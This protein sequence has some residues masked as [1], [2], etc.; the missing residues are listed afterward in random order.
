MFRPA[1]QR[2]EALLLAIDGVHLRSE[3]KKQPGRFN[4]PASC[5]QRGCIAIFATSICQCRRPAQQGPQLGYVSE[6]GSFEDIE[7]GAV[8]PQQVD[9]HAVSTLLREEQWPVKLPSATN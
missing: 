3:Y 7:C 9:R 6:C 4:V 2:H 1:M 5:M 8:A